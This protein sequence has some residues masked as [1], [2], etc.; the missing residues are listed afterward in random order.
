MRQVVPEFILQKNDK[1]IYTGSFNAYVLSID[2]I[3]FSELTNNLMK[4]SFKDGVEILS[5]FI[6]YVFAPTIRAVET[7]GG[8]I[9]GFSGDSRTA[10]FNFLE[11]EPAISA[12]LEIRTFFTEK[13]KLKTATGDVSLPIRVGLSRGRVDWRIIETSVKK[14]FYF[15]GPAIIR[16]NKIQ[17]IAANNEIVT[18][19]SVLK[20]IELDQI[21][22]HKLDNVY[23]VLESAKVPDLE[24]EIIPSDFTA[25]SFFEYDLK[26]SGLNNELRE[27]ITC[28]INLK[29]ITRK[30]VDRIMILCVKYNGFFNKIDTNEKGIFVIVLFGAPKQFEKPFYRALSFAVELRDLFHDDIRAGI[31]SG[32]CY[33]GFVGSDLRS[34]YTVLGKSVNLAARLVS[35][36]RWGNLLYD[37]YFYK[38]TK[39]HVISKKYSDYFSKGYESSINVYK[40]V[41]ETSKQTDLLNIKSFHGRS[42]ELER[43][44]RF[45]Y[46]KGSQGLKNVF[47]I[48]AEAGQGKTRLVRELIKS[49]NDKFY[50]ALFHCDH[51]VQTPLKPFMSWFHD[52]FHINT[53]DSSKTKTKLFNSKWNR[54]N[55]Q[56]MEIENYQDLAKD[57]KKIKSLIKMLLNISQKTKNPDP[58][59]W[60]I[61]LALA[62]NK[63]LEIISLLKPTVIILEDLHLIDEESKE[64]FYHLLRE[65][66]KSK[67]K[68]I[69]T[70]RVLDNDVRFQEESGLKMSYKK[71]VLQNLKARYINLIIQ[72]ILHSEVHHELSDFIIRTSKGN[73]FFVEQSVS[74]LINSGTLIRDNHKFRLNKNSKGLGKEA[75]A[76]LVSRLD[77]LEHELKNLVH[78]ACVIGM[79]FMAGMLSDMRSVLDKKKRVKNRIPVNVLLD[80]GEKQNIWHQVE[81][82]RY[83]FRHQLLQEA[84]YEMQLLKNLRRIHLLAALVL[85]KQLVNNPGLCYDI[86]DHF[87]KAGLWR[88]AI[89]FYEKAGEYELDLFN[90][91]ASLTSYQASLSLSL[92]Y[93]GKM[94]PGTA[95]AL[96]KLATIFLEMTNYKQALESAC[97]SYEIL[98]KVKG[99]Q[100]KDTFATLKLIGDSHKQWGKMDKAMIVYKKAL[101]LHNLYHQ[102]DKEQ[103]IDLL[104]DTAFAYMETYKYKES[105]SLFQ[106]VL[107]RS[108][109]INIADKEK[110][111]KIYTGLGEVF[112][113]ESELDKSLTYFQRSKKILL[114]KYPEYHP[115]IAN[116]ENLIANVYVE[117][118]EYN[119]A[120]E[121]Y[122]RILEIYNKYFIE[123]TMSIGI[124]VKIA[125]L[126]CRMDDHKESINYLKIASNSIKRIYGKNHIENIGV[127]LN[128]TTVYF[129][130]NKPDQALKTIERS[131]EIYEIN[132]KPDTR[133]PVIY[134]TS[135]GYAYLMKKEYERSLELYQEALSLLN[136]KHEGDHFLKAE[137][138]GNIGGIHMYQNNIDVSLSYYLQSLNMF[139]RIYSSVHNNIIN[140]T[141][142]VAYLYFR[143]KEYN[144]TLDYSIQAFEWTSDRLGPDHL[145]TACL[146]LNIGDV[147]CEINDY[148]SALKRAQYALERFI[149][150][151]GENHFYTAKAFLMIGKAYCKM[152]FYNKGYDPIHKYV[153]Y[154]KTVDSSYVASND[155]S[156]EFI[157]EINDP[158]T[159]EQYRNLLI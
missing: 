94:H 8:F 112:F 84:A 92:R 19:D 147:Y 87:L 47:F 144:K 115:K 158:N 141:K 99:L 70:S 28:F 90:L 43:L 21:K 53:K 72:D 66:K 137:C 20:R 119:K 118:T 93:R 88:K 98:K 39:S 63:F 25:D 44:M 91:P 97:K 103:M 12:A 101:E 45:C 154:N 102:S 120:L 31:A 4:D 139:K 117:K 37:E 30:I 18:H 155:E 150:H 71:M 52:F 136:N 89:E 69:F 60:L 6:N 132:G 54:I 58:K 125:F 57:L 77:R 56:L 76:L 34:E 62:I 23:R 68:F 59:T 74:Y 129:A 83:T 33:A 42:K 116:I 149:K 81:N 140:A 127:L 14:V 17:K 82:N 142:M 2:L 11:P 41:A 80:E 130:K 32:T 151:F 40:F 48:C 100:N 159:A 38:E 138:L 157:K 1:K 156:I 26:L 123:G 27:V 29:K 3:N 121:I 64:I 67:I 10:V 108:I 22:L 49:L 85:E 86:A 128:L 152:G 135:S 126:K 105:I 50:F 78:I 51:I 114:K 75:K 46:D 96:K 133:F 9:T 148:P 111:A 55:Q 79:D 113:R 104:T 61:N 110:I 24:K 131:R 109:E 146:A 106:D 16:A 7:K 13:A 143:K 65:I 153:D 35:K 107:D 5:N 15:S 122:M 95:S 145:Y 124:Y 36:A 73:P 134:L